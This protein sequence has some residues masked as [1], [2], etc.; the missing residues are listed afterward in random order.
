[1]T[2]YALGLDC[3]V[4]VAGAGPPAQGPGVPPESSNI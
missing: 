2:A 3:P 1:M 4:D